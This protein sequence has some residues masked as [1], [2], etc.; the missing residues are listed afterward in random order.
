MKHFIDLHED[1]GI[2]ELNYLL[3]HSFCLLFERWFQKLFEF[4][5]EIVDSGTLSTSTNEVTIDVHKTEDGVWEI[6]PDN[7]SLYRALFGGANLN[8]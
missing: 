3:I 7:D 8:F 4:F 5:Y 1:V 2:E 6:D